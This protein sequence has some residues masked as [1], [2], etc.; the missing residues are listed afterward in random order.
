MQHLLLYILIIL[1]LLH[2]H[3]RRNSAAP[4]NIIYKLIDRY[5]VGNSGSRLHKHSRTLRVSF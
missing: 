1:Y 4:Q 5:M 2:K 3:K